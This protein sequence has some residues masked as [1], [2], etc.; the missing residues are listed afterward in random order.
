MTSHLH[1]A[2]S[3]Y[4]LVPERFLLDAVIL[5]KGHVTMARPWWSGGEEAMLPVQGAQVQSLVRELDPTCVC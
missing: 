3:E 2:L 1:V 5:V 4:S